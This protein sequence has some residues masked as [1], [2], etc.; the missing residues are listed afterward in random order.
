MIECG[1]KSAASICA[2]TTRS[3]KQDLCCNPGERVHAA[4]ACTGSLHHSETTASVIPLAAFDLDVLEAETGSDVLG[5]T[6]CEAS[7]T[8]RPSEREHFS[9]LSEGR[10]RRNPFVATAYA[11]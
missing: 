8:P 5:Q 7:T 4:P 2:Q 9:S 1:R 3:L 6:V 11:L 10:P